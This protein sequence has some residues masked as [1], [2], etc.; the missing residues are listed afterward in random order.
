MSQANADVS[1]KKLMNLLKFLTL[2]KI[3]K[4]FNFNGLI[5][6][7]DSSQKNSCIR[8]SLAGTGV[9]IFE[10]PL[11]HREIKNRPYQI[12]LRCPLML[13]RI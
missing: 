12:E 10:S 9:P 7:K 2:L 3:F 13:P 8:R 11:I 1:R 6:C 5:V 4:I